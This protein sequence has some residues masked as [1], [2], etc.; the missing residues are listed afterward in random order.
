MLAAAG[1]DVSAE[2]ALGELCRV[3]WFPIYAYVRRKGRGPADAEDLTQEFFAKVVE[4]RPF[5]ELMREGGKFRSFLL[6]AMD[7]MLVDDWRRS[8]TAKRGA[9]K[10]VSLD[11]GEAETRFLREPVERRTPES[12]FDLN[13]AMALLERVYGELESEFAGREELFAALKPCLMGAK[14]ELP[15]AELA[16]QLGLTEGAVKTHVHRLRA[17]FRALLREAV[18]QIV[19][20]P[21]EIDEELRALLRV[22]AGG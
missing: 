15:Y 12:Q 8:Q 19:A 14:A 20:G 17:R 4:R 9:G 2:E 11:D 1:S 10:V 22:I 6:R 13:F 7:R 16:A 21:E 3:Y 18:G 5:G